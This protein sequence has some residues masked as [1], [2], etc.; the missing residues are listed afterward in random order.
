MTLSTAA[1]LTLS[2]YAWAM[3]KPG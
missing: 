2:R 1:D 3:N